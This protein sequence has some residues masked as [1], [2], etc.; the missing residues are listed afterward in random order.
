MTIFSQN[1]D[2]NSHTAMRNFLWRHF[3]Y[4]TMNSWNNSTSYAHNMK[5]THLGL[6]SS[7]VDKLF[8]L[9]QTEEFYEPIRNLISEFGTDHNY[10]WQAGFNGRSG[11][12]LV[13]YQ[14]EQKPSG[15]K[16]YCT[17]CGQRNYKSV[18][19]NGSVCG[20]CH[21]PFRV[22]YTQ[23]HMSV[24]TFPGRSVDQQVSF[25]SWDID[26]LQHRVGIVCDFDK[27]A[28]DIVAEAVY[29]A[30][31]YEVEEKTFYVPQTRK[32][33]VGA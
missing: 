6:E 32:V 5:I 25:G 29:M 20:R 4:N 30:H 11:G 18:S 31:N 7:I 3:R 15:Y 21:K 24:N 23:T 14:G 19:E 17:A 27:L 8:D 16:S 2:R 9:I 22:D 26:S 13:L 12:Y 28:D 33:L 10:E 1:V